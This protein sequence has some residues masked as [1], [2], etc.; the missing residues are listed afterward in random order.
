MII[1]SHL[2]LAL[3]YQPPFPPLIHRHMAPFHQLH[4]LT[5]H[6]PPPPNLSLTG[7]RL[8]KSKFFL[9]CPSVNAINDHLE[10]VGN[11]LAPFNHPLVERTLKIEPGKDD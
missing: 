9:R 8:P 10:E 2:H 6:H 1:S 3:P 5:P 11:P 7:A 4:L